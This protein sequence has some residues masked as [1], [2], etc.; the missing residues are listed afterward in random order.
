MNPSP[1]NLIVILGPTASG[2]TAFAAHLAYEI[3]GEIISADSRQLYKKMNV[4][5]GKDYEDYIVHETKIPYHLIDIANPGYKYNVYEFQQDFLKAYD[6]IR[7]N[8]RFPVLCGGTGMYIEAVTKN[9]ELIAVP[10]NHEL[11]EELDKKTDEELTEILKSYRTLHNTSD[12][13]TRKRL[14]RAIEIVMYQYN[15]SDKKKKLPTIN[16][17]YIGIKFDRNTRRERITNRL[18][19]RLNNGMIKEVEKLLDDGVAPDDL[20]FYGLEYK[21]VTHY[22]TN[23]LSYDDM[24]QKLNIAI[25]QFAKRQMTWFRKM[26]RQGDHIHW[27]DGAS[28]M[29][30]KV[31]KALQWIYP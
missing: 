20:I 26:E 1:Y 16:P 10:L 24:V 6:L 28:P 30:H 23:K 19:N 25:H 5:T 11:R 18:Y 17:L 22:L 8:N 2:K 29:P 9:Y 12:T 13:D 3:E 4:G 7:S 14:I 21:Y 15:N 27:I 31:E